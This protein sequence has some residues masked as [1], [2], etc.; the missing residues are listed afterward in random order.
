[1]ALTS[2]DLA[3][4]GIWV[5]VGAAVG[6]NIGMFSAI[7]HPENVLMGTV[8]GIAVGAVFGFMLPKILT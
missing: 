5:G 8:C 7:D 3:N 1:M 2:M 4:I 6:G